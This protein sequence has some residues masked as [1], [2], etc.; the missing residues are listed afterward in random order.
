MT[1]TNISTFEFPSNDTHWKYYQE[2]HKV[3]FLHWKVPL[4]FITQLLPAGISPDLYHETAWITLMPFSVKKMRFRKFPALPYVSKFDQVNLLT[5][6]IKDNKPGIYIFSIEASKLSTMLWTHLLLGIKYKNSYIKRDKNRYSAENETYGHRLEIDYT[7]RK[8][9]KNKTDLDNWLL[10]RHALY[11]F[12]GGKWYHSNIE[13]KEIEIKKLQLLHQ[14]INYKTDLFEW[15]MAKLDK[16]HYADK[17]K[18]RI[19]ER[20]LLSKNETL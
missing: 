2:W 19:S 16:M 8:Y 15:P 7:V 14:Y 17:V 1:T 9:R 4:S 13:R 12:I 18:V 11:E 3:L 6:V 20:Q 5:Y 10:E